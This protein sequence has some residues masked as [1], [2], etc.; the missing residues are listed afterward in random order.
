MGLFGDK[1]S[2]SEE[3]Y[4]FYTLCEQ[5][6]MTADRFSADFDSPVE[7]CIPRAPVK[8]I[9][10]TNTD[11][12]LA[13]EFMSAIYRVTRSWH[14]KYIFALA[15]KG[16]AR[17]QGAGRLDEFAQTQAARA[18]ESMMLEQF[19]E[20]SQFT[21]IAMA[22][23]RLAELGNQPLDN[24]IEFAAKALYCSAM[25]FSDPQGFADRIARE[26]NGL[27][28]KIDSARQDS[29]GDPDRL[30]MLDQYVKMAME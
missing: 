14:A 12:R 4:D 2:L 27:K 7:Q 23:F 20:P 3:G 13:G 10:Q 18:L 26:Q 1:K 24:Y 8:A 25:K 19:A 28:L 22:H 11:A 15:V 9:R 17:Q 5:A 16:A 29:Q 6:S 21:F 30:A